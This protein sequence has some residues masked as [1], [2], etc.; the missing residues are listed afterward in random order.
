MWSL[1]HRLNGYDATCV[2]LAEVTD[3]T[4][5]LATSARLAKAPGPG[6]PSSYCDHLAG[7]NSADRWPR[8]YRQRPS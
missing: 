5:L 8:Q 3:A 2:A 4:P 1:G 6:A 7:I